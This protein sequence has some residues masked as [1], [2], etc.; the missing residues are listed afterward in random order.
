MLIAYYAHHHGRGHL[1]RA[2][3]LAA[4][5]PGRVVLLSSYEGPT[6]AP[7]A[8]R[9]RLPLDDGGVAGTEAVAGLLHYAPLGSRGLATRMAAIADVLASGDVG[10]CV[11]DVSV[12]V[13]LLARLHGVPVVWVRQHG[14]RSDAPHRLAAAAA[15]VQVVP[16]PAWLDRPAVASLPGPPA[17]T[18]PLVHVGGLSVH[19]GRAMS[20]PPGTR[21]VLV[22]DG[23][24]GSTGR[25]A[26]A[27]HVAAACPGWTVESCGPGTAGGRDGVVDHG[28]CADPFGLLQRA[29]VVVASAG[30]NAVMDVAAAGR[31]LVCVPQDRPYGE[32]HAKARALEAAGVA[33]CVED[34]MGADWPGELERARRRPVDRLRTLVDPAA[35]RRFLGVVEDAA[36][37]LG[38][39][40]AA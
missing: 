20:P 27:A 39:A 24:G 2:E 7:F 13:A 6:A 8:A 17:A 12:E 32:Q 3:Q 19:A 16:W 15:A 26:L 29:D 5:A 28:W 18:A 35:P 37:R 14:H 23:T 33:S 4:A 22:L 11:V 31:P 30:T 25:G 40:R 38:L 21:R 1:L 34:P 9:V 10:A 36:A